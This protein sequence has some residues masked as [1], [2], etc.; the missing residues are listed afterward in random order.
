[1]VQQIFVESVE[2]TSASGT[3]ASTIGCMNEIQQ[4]IL[5]IHDQKAQTW[6][7]RAATQSIENFSQLDNMLRQYLAQAYDTKIVLDEA[8]A[9]YAA[10]EAAQT[11][12]VGQLDT[13]GI[14]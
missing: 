1:M 6:W 12:A 13:S 5:R 4:A 10:T 8:V 7:G 3:M 14:F 11:A 9:H 2:L